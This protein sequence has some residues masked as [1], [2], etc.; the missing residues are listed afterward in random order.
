MSAT[1]A[2]ALI[3]VISGQTTSNEIITRFDKASGATTNQPPLPQPAS[4][5]AGST[6]PVHPDTVPAVTTSIPPAPAVTNAATP[7][8]SMQ[9]TASATSV[10]EKKDRL[11]KQLEEIR[12]KKQEDEAK[13]AREKEIQRRRTGQDIQL[14]QESHAERQRRKYAEDVKKE[15]LAEAEHRRK[16]REQIESDKRE[17]AAQR[18]REIEE[19]QK[20]NNSP[21]SK[22]PSTSASASKCSVCNLNIRQLDGSQIRKQF[23]ATDTLEVVMAWIDKERTDGDAPYML[24]AQFPTR[25]FSI[26]DEARSLRELELVP[27]STLIMKPSRKV[28]SAYIANGPGVWGY[29][30]SAVDMAYSVAGTSWTFVNNVL[31]TLFPSSGGIT[32]GTTLGAQTEY[33]ENEDST[34]SD[35]RAAAAVR[36]KRSNINTLAS[37]RDD[38][39]DPHQTYNGNS[40]NQE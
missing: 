19:R 14:A 6:Q 28:T 5:P 13:N 32:G 20:G 12:K 8:T 11:K 39:R 40:V 17:R 36:G 34:S 27:S 21:T 29:A 38:D 1:R 10:Q 7:P 22:S 2:G 33:G 25:Q 24:L 31:G 4:R 18:Q 37:I 3:D 35:V 16:L 26:G 9:Q 15:K 23:E 30:N